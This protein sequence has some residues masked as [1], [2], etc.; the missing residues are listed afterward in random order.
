[1]AKGVDE[2]NI[3]GARQATARVASAAVSGAKAAGQ[4]YRSHDPGYIEWSPF[5]G[6]DHFND[7]VPND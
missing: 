4:T 2:F 6:K 3:K 5:G 7:T 1:V